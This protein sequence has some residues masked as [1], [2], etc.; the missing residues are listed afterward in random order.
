MPDV[1]TQLSSAGKTA[2]DRADN[3]RDRPSATNRASALT[4]P[5]Y[6]IDFVDGQR[7]AAAPIQRLKAPPGTPKTEYGHAGGNVTT[8]SKQSM[9]RATDSWLSYE[10]N[11]MQL[12]G[13]VP[14]EDPPGYTYIRNADLTNLWIR[15]HL[16]NESAGGPG[17]AKNLVPTSQKTNQDPDWKAME[18]A[19]KAAYNSGK[20]YHFATEVAYHSAVPS[21]AQ[22]GEKWKHLFPAGIYAKLYKRNA[23]D[24]AWVQTKEVKLTPNLP[25]MNPKLMEF[26]LSEMT[27]GMIKN[28]GTSDTLA[29]FIEQNSATLASQADTEDFMDKL[30]ELIG[31]HPETSQATRRRRETLFR[32][33]RSADEA[34]RGRINAKAGIKL[35]LA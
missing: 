1:K 30:D 16:V 35:V 34:L 23:S 15:F 7:Q 12:D 25:P 8:P 13:S 28:L 4:P 19:E 21:P 9:W 29:D 18:T 14:S 5:A 22:E 6:G 11:A 32:D 24:T 26:K 2:R 33:F 31:D 10:E 20:T 17:K 3:P 27:A